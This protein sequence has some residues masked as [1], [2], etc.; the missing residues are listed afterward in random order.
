MSSS[1]RNLHLAQSQ[2]S[3][4]VI[5]RDTVA[6]ANATTELGAKTTVAVCTGMLVHVRARMLYGFCT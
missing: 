5:A 3:I 2:Y 6:A 4:A 1:C